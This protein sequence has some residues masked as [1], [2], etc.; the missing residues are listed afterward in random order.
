MARSLDRE[1]HG[2]AE[3]VFHLLAVNEEHEK[4]LDD[5][6]WKCRHFLQE[7]MEANVRLLAVEKELKILKE[8]TGGHQPSRRRPLVSDRRLLATKAKRCVICLS[9]K[10][11]VIFV[12]CGH[13]ASCL[14]CANIAMDAAESQGVA[15]H[16]PICRVT[17]QAMGRFF[18]A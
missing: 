18:V 1:R 12:P 4:E 2:K 6:R 15:F 8:A 11:D 5:L 7:K 9:A 13:V 10:R 16:C 17:C 14:S 3:E